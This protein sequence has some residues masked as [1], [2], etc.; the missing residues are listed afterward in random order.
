M[1]GIAIYLDNGETL[2]D[3]TSKVDQVMYAI[4]STNKNKYCFVDKKPLTSR[5]RL[6][7]FCIVIELGAAFHK[8]IVLDALFFQL[9]LQPANG[10]TSLII[11]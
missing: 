1:T 11:G 3:L 8:V 2:H 10:L 4:K 5:Q 7:C 6:M 9:I